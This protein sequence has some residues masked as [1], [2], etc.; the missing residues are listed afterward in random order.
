[1]RVTDGSV[2]DNPVMGVNVI[3]STT[4]AQITSQ[5][6]GQ[7]G[8]SMGGEGGMP[9][10]LG[11][12]QVQVMTTVNGIASIIPSAGNVG[13][14]DLFIAVSAGNS[15]VQFQMENEAAIVP[16]QPKSTFPRNTTSETLTLFRTLVRN[17]P[18]CKA[19]QTRYSLFRNQC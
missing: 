10:I 8:E 12:S 1:M 4:L 19:R 18:G 2:A 13:P 17:R 5:S 15:T 11:S 14:C 9:V 7:V 3:F 16:V 6:G